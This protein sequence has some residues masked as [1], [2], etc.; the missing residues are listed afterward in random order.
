[1]HFELSVAVIDT[2]INIT[3]Y[4][5]KENLTCYWKRRSIMKG[6]ESILTIEVRLY[7]AVCSCSG[8]AGRPINPNK[9]WTW[10]T[11]HCP[12]LTGNKCRSWRH[13]SVV[14][15]HARS[16]Y[17]TDGWLKSG[18]NERAMLHVW[19]VNWPHFSFRVLEKICWEM[20]TYTYR[21]D[22]LPRPEV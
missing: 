15:V 17:P 19:M 22:Q 9:G 4:S 8:R 12:G 14:H 2:L 16:A 20:I 13:R 18:V 7:R 5:D 10:A 1:M 3:L 6:W 21:E 11:S